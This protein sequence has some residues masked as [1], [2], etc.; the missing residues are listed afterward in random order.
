MKNCLTCKYWEGDKIA[1][2]KLIE[3]CGDVVMDRVHGFSGWGGCELVWEWLDIEIHGDATADKEV[4][5]NFGCVWHE[6]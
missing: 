3:S 2:H 5:A 6:N 1:T 4:P